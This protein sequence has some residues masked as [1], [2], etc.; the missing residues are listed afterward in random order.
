[1]LIGGWQVNGIATLLSG[2]PFTPQVGSNRSGD[3]DTRNPDRPS[4]NPAFSGEVITGK[5]TQW[6]NPNAFVLP[7]V[8]TYGN[9]G[10]G[11]YTGP[12]LATLDFSLFKNV[13]I[14]ERTR[15]QF[16][17]EAFNT[18]NHTKPSEPRMPV[19]SRVASRSGSDGR[20]PL[21]RP[22]QLPGRSKFGLT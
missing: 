10:R 18:M 14:T 1:M 7:A 20:T 4:L 2:F 6:Y 11:V 3:G 13:A 5:Q 9:L 17:A 19:S 22:P 12:G 15:L 8:G 21:R 16:R